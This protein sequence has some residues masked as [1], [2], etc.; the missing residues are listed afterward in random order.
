M[1]KLIVSGI[2]SLSILSFSPAFAISSNEQVTLCA[3]ALVSNGSTQDVE[4]RAKFKKSRGGSV[5]TVKIDLVP[6]SGG[7]KLSGICKIKGGEVVEAEVK[8]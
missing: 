8:A 5:K 1:N 7:E 2:A 4:Y 6:V 3:S